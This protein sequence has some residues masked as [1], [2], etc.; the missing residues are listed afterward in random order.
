MKLLGHN[1]VDASYEAALKTGGK[2]N[3]AP[4]PRT[5]YGPNYYGAFVIDPLGNNI[6]AVH[7]G[8]P[9]SVTWFRSIFGVN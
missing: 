9:E 1:A 2:D 3:G 8:S 5:P 4:G 6:E 7:R